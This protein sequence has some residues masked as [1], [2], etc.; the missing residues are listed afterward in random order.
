[1]YSCYVEKIINVKK[2]KNEPIKNKKRNKKKQLNSL[3]VQ[4]CLL[5]IIRNN[6][7]L[8][9]STDKST[10]LSASLMA[11]AGMTIEAAI[12]IPL[13][14]L[15]ML[16]LIYFILIMNF[17]N[18]LCQNMTNTARD[19]SRYSFAVKT[20]GKVIEGNPVSTEISKDVSQRL[21]DLSV[22]NGVIK[23]GLTG[24]YALNEILD[25][26]VKRLAKNLGMY[27]GIMG[28]NML[29]SNLS[30]QENVDLVFAYT[31]KI[32]MVS[33][34]IYKMTFVNRC[35]FRNFIGKS[36]NQKARNSY[37]KVYITRNGKVY[38]IYNDC[39]HIELSIFSVPFSSL[40]SLRNKGGGKY[41]KCE[42]CVISKIDNKDYVT[43]TTDGDRYHCRRECSGITRNVLIVDIS[44]VGNRT[45]CKR[46]REREAQ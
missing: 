7:S 18:L 44:Q 9:F 42:K 30:E 21:E 20:I 33:S 10:S 23:G 4:G 38:H 41:K 5:N 3:Q 6:N 29:E 19:I 34:S 37:E 13:I 1:M 22:T 31:V 35:Y 8:L 12:V 27:N 25:D 39:T 46:C 24:I 17:Q 32:P 45:L 15:G 28:I 40:P 14:L 26:D 2:A 16:S 43:V 36:I 11:K